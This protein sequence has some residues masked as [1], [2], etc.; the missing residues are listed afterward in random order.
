MELKHQYTE[1]H[2]QNKYQLL[3]VPYGIET[4]NALT[5]RRKILHF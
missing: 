3:I 1:E 5:S 2:N 4:G